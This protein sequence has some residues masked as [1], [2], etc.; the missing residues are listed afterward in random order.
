ML[1]TLMCVFSHDF[2][3]P[4]QLKGSFS[5]PWPSGQKPCHGC[6][7]RRLPFFP[8]PPIPAFL[9]YRA[10]D[11][12]VQRSRLPVDCLSDFAKLA[13]SHFRQRKK[14]LVFLPS[15]IPHTSILFE[16]RLPAGVPAVYTGSQP[17][18]T[19]QQQSSQYTNKIDTYK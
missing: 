16:I 5:L 2:C 19:P 4:A 13:L 3:F 1:M 10:H 8:P 11:R 6:H 18:A 9:F 14:R 15:L 17:S 12:R 7:R